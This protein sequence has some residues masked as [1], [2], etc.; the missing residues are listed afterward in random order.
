MKAGFDCANGI[1]GEAKIDHFSARGRIKGEMA[2]FA[3]N[4]QRVRIDVLSPFGALVFSLTSNGDEFRMFDLEKKQ[5]LHGPASACNLARMT[6]VEVPGHALVSIMRGEAPLL[7]HEPGA[8]AIAWDDGHY[9]IDIPSENNARQKVILEVH[10]DDFDK[11][12]QEQRLRVSYLEVE[13]AGIV[14]YTADF[15]DHEIAHLA[16]PRVDPEGLDDPIAPSG[17]A[18]D[19]EIPRTIQLKVPHTDDDVIFEYEKAVVNPPI[20]LGAFSQPIP[21]GTQQLYVSCE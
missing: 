9:V 21:G 8:A 10:D 11:P 14:L 13:Q 6:Q 3:V 19:I 12:W 18:C 7:V 16:P 20:P 5:F 17:G 15:S 1:Q 4:P 2:L